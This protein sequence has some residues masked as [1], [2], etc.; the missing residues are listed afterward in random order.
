MGPAILGSAAVQIN[1]AVNSN[2][3]TNIQDPVRGPDGPVS[4]LLYA[5]RFMQLPLGLFG[6]AIGSAT[7]PAISRSAAANNMEEFR[8]T[9][10][11]SL[12]M[13]FLLTVPSSVGL[14]VLGQ[15][16]VGAI[17]Q[18]GRFQTYDTQQTAIAL[19]CYALGLAGYS[20]TKVLTPAFYALGDARTPMYI[21]LI[22]IA[23]NLITVITMLRFTDLGHAGLALS[24]SAVATVSSLAL[25][26]AIKNRLGGIYGR[27]LLST[28]LKVSLASA[29]MG[30]VVA[31][32]T[33]QITGA[34]GTSP[35]ARLIDLAL[36]IPAG[37]AIL[38]ILCRALNVA[39]LE[40]AVAA[41]KARFA[42]RAKSSA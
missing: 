20:A 22:S 23:V 16:V 15:S 28:V 29:G 36:S 31:V 32:S 12:G 37:I 7:L 4:W 6:V 25:F 33:R 8:R 5:F 11:R 17:Y 39:E 14:V 10:S 13:V 42:R 1:A 26:V 18:T 30:A 40:S 21:S 2:F 3:A 35:A 27:G 38:Y 19:S 24:T 34:F 41:V 9:L